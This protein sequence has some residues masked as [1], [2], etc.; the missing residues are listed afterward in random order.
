MRIEFSRIESI[1]EESIYNSLRTKPIDIDS[2]SERILE[3]SD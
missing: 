1:G 2:D 3:L